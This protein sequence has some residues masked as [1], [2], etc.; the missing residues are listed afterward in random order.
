MPPETTRDLE[1]RVAAL[2][3][4]FANMSVQLGEERFTGS[5][6]GD[7]RLPDGCFATTGFQFPAGRRDIA[8]FYRAITIVTPKKPEGERSA[9]AA[10]D[11]PTRVH[12]LE[13]LCTGLRLEIDRSDKWFD[14]RHPF[15][16]TNHIVP[17]DGP[18]V[19]T[20]LWHGDRHDDVALLYGTLQ[21]IKEP[22][23]Q[24]P[25]AGT[26]EERVEYV[27]GDLA[28]LRPILTEPESVTGWVPRAGASGGKVVDGQVMSGIGFWKFMS[29]PLALSWE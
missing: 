16:S 25:Y 24:R 3:Y 9:A 13:M 20:G 4:S 27:E 19:L 12:L 10:G 23:K 14:Y 21:L 28:R 22:R 11:L 29:R 15:R 1:S 6:A 8:L 7:R 26:L 18:N 2:E 17:S 5:L